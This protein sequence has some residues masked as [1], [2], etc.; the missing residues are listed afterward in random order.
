MREHY[1]LYGLAISLGFM[2]LFF[3]WLIFEGMDID[4]F[5][6]HYIDG[7]YDHPCDCDG[8]KC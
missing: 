3:I 1:F 2:L 5:P 6:C 4:L 7:C 8:N